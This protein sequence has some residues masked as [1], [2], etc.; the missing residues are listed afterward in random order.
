MKI[1]LLNIFKIVWRNFMS[2]IY[3]K[4]IK[5]KEQNKDTMYLFRNGNFYIFLKEDAER[6]NEY[7]VLKKTKFCKEA[8]KCGFPV[9]SLEE[10]MHVF[11][12][13]GLDVQ[14]I[15]QVE[16]TDVK[17]A[18]EKLKNINLDKTTPIQALQ[19]LKE[20]QELL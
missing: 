11:H 2:R 13:H 9:S 14:I 3:N 5:L 20:L 18:L 6:I 10:Y 17:E 15:S 7:V 12:N 4:Y 1:Y 16:T 8:M 19:I